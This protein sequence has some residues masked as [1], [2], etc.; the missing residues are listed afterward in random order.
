[1]SERAEA[2]LELV[3]AEFPSLEVS[4]PW[5]RIPDYPIPAAWGTSG[6]ALA[7]QVPAELPAQEPYGFWLQPALVLPGG[8]APTNST[9]GVETGFGPGWQQF[10]WTFDGWKPGA[11]PRSGTN[12]LDFVRSF[13]IRLE[14][15]N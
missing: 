2:E 7:F 5:A 12:M 9:A 8:G 3:R 13:S 4:G 14:E 10:S 11:E 15:L 6:N 1:M